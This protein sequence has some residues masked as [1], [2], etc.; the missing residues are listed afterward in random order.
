MGAH[1]TQAGVRG[2]LP[3]EPTQ[4]EPPKTGGF[5]LINF[6]QRREINM[7][8]RDAFRDAA[9][10]MVPTMGRS[11]YDVVD[12]SEP[13]L[14]IFERSERP[15]WVPLVCIVFFPFGLLAL[16][17]Q[18]SER[19]VVTFDEVGPKLTEMN[20]QGRARRPTRRTFATISFP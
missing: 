8:R 13:E 20:V 12:R 3:P 9:S 4:G 15:A 14:L 11:G 16:L 17:V 1:E 6:H 19:V 5:G 10:S 18:K 7:S 2:E